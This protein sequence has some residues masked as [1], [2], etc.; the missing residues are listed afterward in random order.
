MSGTLIIELET[1]MEADYEFTVVHKE[2]RR[3]N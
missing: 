2:N 3:E 1:I